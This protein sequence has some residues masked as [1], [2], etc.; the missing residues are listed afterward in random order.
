MP[1]GI[2]GVLHVVIKSGNSEA[3][4][5]CSRA[6]CPPLD[7][8]SSCDLKR[9]RL[10]PAMGSALSAKVTPH[11]SHLENS[12]DYPDKAL[13]M[14]SP[15]EPD[16]TFAPAPGKS[17]HFVRNSFFHRYL[18]T[19]REAPGEPWIVSCARRWDG[20][21]GSLTPIS[22]TPPSA[23]PAALPAQLSSAHTPFPCTHA[24]DFSTEGQAHSECQSFSVKHLALFFLNSSSKEGIT[25]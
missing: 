10:S 8:S 7:F 20:Q 3:P 14:R 21:R 5:W 1:N 12:V 23:P 18:Y 25:T 19:S 16:P 6:K 17:R 2:F 22:R 15:P 24:L 11:S 4:G 13:K 9:M